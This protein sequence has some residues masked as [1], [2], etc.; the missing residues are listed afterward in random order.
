ML[1]F[2]PGPL[3]RPEEEIVAFQKLEK[4]VLEKD[5]INHYDYGILRKFA[6]G[7]I[8]NSDKEQEKTNNKFW[9][10]TGLLMQNYK[11]RL[12]EAIE[13]AAKE[14]AKAIWDREGYEVKLVPKNEGGNKND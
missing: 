3:Q 7:V 6:Q 8:F 1:N 14:Y 13:D 4:A 12:Y 10:D 9:E 2:Y 11:R 5:S